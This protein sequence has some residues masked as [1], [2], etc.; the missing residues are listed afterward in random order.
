MSQQRAF[1]A[2]EANSML[3]CISKTITASRSRG[4]ITPLYLALGRPYLEFC[5]KFWATQYKRE[6]DN[7][8][9]VHEIYFV[10]LVSH[11]NWK[12][13]KL[14]EPSHNIFLP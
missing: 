4:M 3:G 8:E 13:K 6:F 7:L 9:R 10:G 5:A 1:A 12:W 14:L 11:R 2:M